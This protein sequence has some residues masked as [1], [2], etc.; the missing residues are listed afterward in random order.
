MPRDDRNCSSH[1]L[2]AG[3]GRHLSRSSEVRL[4]FTIHRFFTDGDSLA[5]LG[6]KIQGAYDLLGSWQKHAP[7]PAMR[8]ISPQVF[9][10]ELVGVG[11]AFLT[12]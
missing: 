2:A 5:Q 10:R 12:A 4:V 6:G 8:R 3:G 7:L 11:D 9:D 1:R